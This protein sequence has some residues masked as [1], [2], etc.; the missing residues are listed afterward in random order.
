M[1]FQS[2]EGDSLFFYKGKGRIIMSGLLFQSPE[3]DSLFF[4]EVQKMPRKI[5]NTCF[6]PPKGIHCFSTRPCRPCRRGR[7]TRAPPAFQSPE[8]DSLFFYKRKL[9]R[10]EKRD[11]EFQSPEGDS[12]FFYAFAA[13]TAAVMSVTMAGFQS[14]EGDSLFF[15][16]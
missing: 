4:Y 10:K 16:E 15:Y 14:P 7:G 9:T 12:L 13:I 2:P 11:N 8:G 3:G 1:T 6:S 5:M